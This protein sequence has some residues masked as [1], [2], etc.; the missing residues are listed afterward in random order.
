MGAGRRGAALDAWLLRSEHE[1]PA[2]R[3]AGAVVDLA[4]QDDVAIAVAIDDNPVERAVEREAAACA[5]GLS[6]P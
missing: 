4:V 2:A 6:R 3:R 1:R 5:N